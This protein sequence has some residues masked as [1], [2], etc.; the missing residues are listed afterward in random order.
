[1][2]LTDYVWIGVLLFLLFY[3]L[4]A[5]TSGKTVTLS[6]VVWKVSVN[7]PIIPFLAGV[8]TGH[9]FWQAVK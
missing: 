8:V 9:F 4:W 5:A 6:E 3:D 2:T 7:R 1:M